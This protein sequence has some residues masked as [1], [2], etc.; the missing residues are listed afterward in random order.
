[1][2]KNIIRIKRRIVGD[3]GSP[4]SLLNGELAYNEVNHVLYYGASASIEAIAGRGMFVDRVTN[5]TISGEKTFEDKAF[6]NDDVDILQNTTIYGNLSVLGDITTIDT[7]LLTTS[8]VEIQNS[9]TGPALKATQTGNQDIAIFYDDTD[10]ALSIKDGGNVGV[11]TFTPN[12]ALTVIGSISATDA[13]TIEGVTNLNSLLNVEGATVI[14]N[15]LNVTDAATFASSVSAQGALTIE[16]VSTLNGAVTINNTLNVTDAVDFDSTLNVDGSTT[17]NDTLSV[18]GAV[19]FDSTLD[20]V[21]ATTLQSTL[22]VDGST[23]INNTLDVT[24][25][26]TFAS[27]LSTA[28][29]VDFDSTLNVDGSTTLNDTLNVTDAVDFDSTLNVDGSTTLNNTLSVTGSVEFDSTLNVDGSTTLNNSLVVQGSTTINNTLSVT[30][31]VTFDKALNIIGDTTI[32]GIL[33]VIGDVRLDST[34]DV[35]GSTTLNNTLSVIGEVD[36]D[37]S[38]N[39]L[40][41]TTIHNTLSVVDAVNFDSTFTAQGATTL[42]DTLNVTGV[43]DISSDLYVTGTTTLRDTLS[44]VG[45]ANFDS[46][47]TVLSST[48]LADTLDVTG[49]VDLGSNLNVIGITTLDNGNITT[50]GA[51]DITLT[52]DISAYGSLTVDSDSLFKSNLTVTNNLTANDITANNISLNSDAYITGNL[53]VY[54]NLTALGDNTVI[55]TTTTVASAFSIT[56]AGSQTALTVTQKGAQD[57]AA[58]FDGELIDPTLIIKD[59]GRV[60]INTSEPSTEL[61]VAGSISASGNVDI[62]GTLSV[63]NAVNFDSTLDVVGITTLDNST[64]YTDGAGSMTVTG[65]IT[66]VGNAVVAEPVNSNHAATKNYVDSG[67]TSLLTTVH[68]VSTNLD[69]KITDL[70]TTVYANSANWDSVYSNVN[71]NSGSWQDTNSSVY[72]NSANWDSVYSNVNATS[73]ENA[74]R[75]Y[76]YSTY[77]PLSGGT[78]AGSLCAVGVH[79]IEAN[80][81]SP[82]L[83]I[84]QTGLGHALRVEDSVNPDSSPFVITSGGQVGIGTTNPSFISGFNHGLHIK[85]TTNTGTELRIDTLDGNRNSAL[86]F[87]AS[88]GGQWRIFN[89]TSDKNSFNIQDLTQPTIVTALTIK[90]GGSVGIAT[91]SPNERLTV[92]GNISASGTVYT[93]NMGNSQLWNDAY[94]NLVTNSAAYLSAVDLSFLSVSGNWDSTYTSVSETSANWDS[95]YSNVNA[96]SALW[97]SNDTDLVNLTGNWE[98]TYTN[99]LSNSGSWQDTNS[100]VYANSANW[101]STYTN[102]NANSANA[103]SVY[104]NVNAN[105]GSWQDTNSSVYANSGNW[106]SVYSNVNATSAENATRDYVYSTYLPLSGGTVVGNVSA[107]GSYYGDGSHLTTLS[108][109]SAIIVDTFS[110]TPALRVTQR[111]SGN[112]IVVED[113]ANPDSTPFIITSAGNACIGAT[114]TQSDIWFN[115]LPGK[116]QVVSQ[117]TP[118]INIYH[119][120][121]L[122]DGQG[123][124]IRKANGTIDL[125]TSLSTNQRIGYLTAQGY[126]STGFG[127]KGNGALEFY[128]AENYTDTTKGTYFKISTTTIGASSREE[129]FRIKDDGKVGIGTTSP[130]ELLTVAGNVSAIRYYGD[131]SQL[132]G[133]IAGDTTATTLVRSNSANWDSV[134][135]N[136]NANSAQWASNDTDLVNL[137]GSW[138]DTNSSVYANSANWDSTYS[139]VRANSANAVSVYSNV[140]ANSATNWNNSIARNYTHTNFL[141]I[142]GGNI[143]GGLTA[144]GIHSTLDLTIGA[145]AAVLYVD[146]FSVGINTESPTQ[147]L[148]VAGSISASGTLMYGVTSTAPVNATTPV[149][150][151]D[152]VVGDIVYKLPLYQ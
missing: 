56:N 64:I 20:V 48:T 9:G 49:D 8:A 85:S 134:Y 21:G 70:N 7:F 119:Y 130:N 23:T 99:V 58:F 13:L 69:T 101:D 137:T 25:A 142:T 91:T 32:N 149:G 108:A 104:S 115:N 43:T 41:V 135:S 102:V 16:G 71:A 93:S 143:T 145:G 67:D 38:L 12:E 26:A 141:P 98:S 17:I 106:D 40:G 120:G 6:F 62:N 39:I 133:I 146:S 53:T 86:V 150:W 74:T 109:T 87:A 52:G 96:N 129:R 18:T 3:P 121:T 44:V 72:A 2:S 65:S 80:S 114:E 90:D 5:Q 30:D 59:G 76:V 148:T 151:V 66:A 95:V 42:G 60:G 82:A 33:S 138:Q 123:L 107:T 103:V 4:T 14:N 54:G 50:N 61:T 45:I 97:A 37:S 29:A 27:T 131:G 105:S 63:T 132:T 110:D 152:V 83:R 139:N 10:C 89:N 118:S 147:T 116:L 111:G 100:S 68:T 35:D 78:V 19:D 47:L 24:S 136:V 92:K 77:L 144:N 22:D 117:N 126:G 34:L 57:V 51:G 84:T 128:A 94:T 11:G 15:T 127:D 28:G 113:S 81:A 122:V 36:F 75:D 112:A 31:D 125:P 73:A 1:M 46:T 88:G 140:N 79:V 124:S 55:E